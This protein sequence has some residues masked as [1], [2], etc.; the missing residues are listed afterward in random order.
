[1]QEPKNTNLSFRKFIESFYSDLGGIVNQEVPQIA[2][3]NAEM[4]RSQ[5]G[6]GKGLRSKYVAQC[7][8]KMKK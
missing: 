2:G 8:K 3:S 4:T 6:G 7:K 5:I 1:M